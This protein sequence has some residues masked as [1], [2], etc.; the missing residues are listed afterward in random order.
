MPAFVDASTL[1]V[2]T[3]APDGLVR[4]DIEHTKVTGRAS[5]SKAEC[6]LPHVVKLARDGRV[7]LVCEGN[8]TQPGSVLE[9]DKD[10]LG[11]K[12]RWSV[13][14]YPDGIDFAE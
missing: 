10:S 8:H 4:I 9:I 3:Q 7:Y 12:K 14:V 11:V 1:L 5:L 13:G 2:P 6:T